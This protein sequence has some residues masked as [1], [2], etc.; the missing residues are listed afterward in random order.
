MNSTGRPAR[1]RPAPVKEEL[2]V[3]GGRLL[4]S[5]MYAIGVETAAARGPLW[6]TA[7]LGALDENRPAALI[8]PLHPEGETFS[9][10]LRDHPEAA[11]LGTAFDDGRLQVFTADASDPAQLLFSRGAAGYVQELEHHGI[12][13]GSLIVIDQADDL[14]SNHDHAALVEQARLYAQWCEQHEHTLLLLFLRSSPLRPVLEANQAALQHCAGLARVQAA[15]GVLQ[16]S[17]DFWQTPQERLLGGCLLLTGAA[18]AAPA[19]PTQDDQPPPRRRSPRHL[20]RVWYCGP[21]EPA[22]ASLSDQIQWLEARSIEEIVRK[23]AQRR[24][25]NALIGLDGSLEFGHLLEQLRLLRD[26][27]G[28]QARIVLRESS[29]RLREHLQR[30]LLLGIGIDTVIAPQEAPATWPLLLL[31]EREESE[32]AADGV[33]LPASLA[34]DEAR[35]PSQA[36]PHGAG[37]GWLAPARFVQEAAR[38]LAQQRELGVPCTLAE[39][40]LP[41]QSCSESAQALAGTRQGD[42]AT[43]WGD[44]LF[45]LLSGCRERDAVQVLSRWAAENGG[46][47][48]LRRI[49]LCCAE[50]AI[51]ERLDDL[52]GAVSALPR[53]EP[54][55][56][57]SDGKVVAMP[58]SVRSSI[59]AGWAAAAAA[60]LLASSLGLA[61]RP[62]AAQRMAVETAPA[63]AAAASAPRKIQRRPAAP[64]PAR[65]ATPAATPRPAAEATVPATPASA[66]T[67]PIPAAAAAEAA[68]LSRSNAAAAAPAQVAAADS[69]TRAYEEQRYADAA[70]LGLIEI[71]QRPGDVDLRYRLANSLAW[72][73]D[74]P[75]ALQ[76]YQ[77]LAGTRWA[78]AARLGRANVLLW[79][80][81]AEQADPLLRQVLAAD[82][83]NP[84]AQ[85]SLIM[86]GRQLRAR[87]SV[88]LGRLSDSGDAS[89]Q[90]LALGHRW[91]NPELTQVFQ[92]GAELRRESDAPEGVRL[93]PREVGL[94]WEH[95]GLAWR[96]QLW[97]SLQASPRTQLHGGG[98]ATLLDGALT[99][100]AARLNWGK[101]AFSP[102][103]LRDGLSA[104][105]LQAELRHEQALGLWQAGWQQVHVSDGND[106]M[107][108]SLKFTP[109]WQPFKGAWA[110]K[111]SVALYG[112]KAEDTVA[113]Y[114]S[115]ADGHY[116]ANASLAWGRWEREWEFQAELK[117]AQRLGGEGA[118]GWSASVG[119]KHWLDNDWALRAEA[120]HDRNRRSGSGYRATSASV[121]LE[122]L[123]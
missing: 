110:P 29:W 123:W 37:H 35:A 51:D 33:T 25:A 120:S 6:V 43:Q 4:R 24:G 73:G 50:A 71:E 114:W 36:Q 13:P 93:H 69:A 9:R 80:G 44:A 32:L 18:P 96:P 12:E 111:V 103:A 118:N 112:R 11:R 94:A 77:A 121:T 45:F 17:L 74:Y 78:G 42:I 109:A 113:R 99:L 63:P 26:A 23:A 15:A 79:S 89:R 56:G 72:T 60:L 115:P 54:H 7:L 95:R 2:P 28:P 65:K 104:G 21:A 31:G 66:P 14:F 86:A 55:P 53:Q 19:A 97:G 52:A 70:R 122:R 34:L 67:A 91:W 82:P 119:G 68:P 81:R 61:P 117:R 102:Q 16:L 87:S 38:R 49:S 58:S 83:K 39:V 107:D 10:V 90:T 98:S 64:A 5:A 48:G 116:V 101:A 105:Q 30:R 76:Q 85:D 1:K 27:L 57:S 106:L 84:D 20:P 41:A 3:L 40:H 47:D 92:A 108:L 8:S 75:R 22:L 59:A 46:S 62:A 100:S 88:Q